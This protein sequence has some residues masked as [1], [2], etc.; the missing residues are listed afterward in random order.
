MRPAAASSLKAM[1]ADSNGLSSTGCGRGR[2]GIFGLAAGNNTD[3]LLQTAPSYRRVVGAPAGCGLQIPSA[4][5]VND[6]TMSELDDRLA[7]IAQQGLGSSSRKK[8]TD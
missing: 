3:L 8:G 1:I 6:L 7:P 5:D 2:T 4:V